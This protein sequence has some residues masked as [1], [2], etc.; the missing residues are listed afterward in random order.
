VTLRD[1][2]VLGRVSNLPTVWTNVLTGLV[3]ARAPFGGELLALLLASL[4]LLYVG[5]MY[6]NDAFDRHWDARHRPERPIP[7][8]RV[9]A[10][11]VFAAGF[12]MLAMGVGLVAAAA[13]WPGLQVGWPPVTAALALALAITAYDAYHKQNPASPLLMG[14]CRVLVYVTAHLALVGELSLPLLRGCLVLLAYLIGLT[15]AAKQ[16]TLARPASWW[17]LILLAAPGIHGAFS[18]ASGWPS[19]VALAGWLSWT[20]Y[21]LW[22][23]LRGGR[24]GVPDAVVRL[25]AGISLVDALLIAGEGQTALAFAA[26]A[27]FG[28]TRGLQRYVPGT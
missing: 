11:S 23:L 21:G 27:G 3:L 26:V 14:L 2:L 25:I 4:S 13:C 18:V 1:A 17:P 9:G 19:A 7:S 24:R 12:G 15:Y 16:E 6:L 10:R 5:G 28:L 22:F 20:V 8:G